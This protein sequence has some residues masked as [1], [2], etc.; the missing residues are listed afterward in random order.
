MTE[1]DVTQLWASFHEELW[2]FIRARVVADADADDLLQEVF[3]KLVTHGDTLRHQERVAGWLFRVAS[4]AVVDHHRAKRSAPLHTEVTDLGEPSEGS[5]HT[6]LAHCVAPFVEL[7]DEPYREALR[8]TELQGVTQVEAASRVGIST[9][10]MKSRVQR[11]RRQLRG[12][13]EE[14][15]HVEVDRRGAVIDF[16]PRGTGLD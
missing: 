3:L 6:D 14:C 9:S 7:L 4:R 16:E 8:L 11:G 13:I 2:R 12:L 15:C 10:G 1:H 5:P